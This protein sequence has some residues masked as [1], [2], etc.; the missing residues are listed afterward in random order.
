VVDDHG[1]TRDMV[2]MILKGIGFTDVTTAENGE[3]AFDAVK[4]AY[5][6]LIICDWNMPRFT[7]LE[8]LTAVRS[9]KDFEDTPFLMLTAEAY[10]DSVKAALAA[11][12]TDYIAKP[13]T[14]GVLG[15]KVLKALNLRA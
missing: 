15:Q 7:G 2:R 11:G 4:A 9:N 8:L 1:L 14:A 3:V 5:F 13:F 12:V 10:R 6:D